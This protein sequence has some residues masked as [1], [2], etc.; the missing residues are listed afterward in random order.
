MWAALVVGRDQDVRGLQVPV[1]HEV[2]MRVRD[3]VT[4]LE[5]QVE[6][7]PHGQAVPLRVGRDGLALDEL[8]REVRE[9]IAG[10]A[11]V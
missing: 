10:H 7:G 1:H 8:H 2:A 6:A 3:G 11:T 5:E 4:R 9:A